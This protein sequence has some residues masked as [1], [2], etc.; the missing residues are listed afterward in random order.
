MHTSAELYFRRTLTP[1]ETREIREIVRKLRNANNEIA[2]ASNLESLSAYKHESTVLY[3]SEYLRPQYSPIV[4][5][6]AADG[7]GR[8]GSP[9]GIYYLTSAYMADDSPSNVKLASLSAIAAI[10]EIVLSAK[11]AALRTETAS[12]MQLI[13]PLSRSYF[14]SFASSGAAEMRE[15][16]EDWGPILTLLGG[17]RQA[18]AQMVALLRAPDVSTEFKCRICRLFISVPPND[19]DTLA[20]V[21]TQQYRVNSNLR[22]LTAILQAMGKIGRGKVLLISV[23][24]SS[25]TIYLRKTAIESLNLY[26]GVLL[27]TELLPLLRENNADLLDS[28]LTIVSHRIIS[29]SIDELIKNGIQSP[30]LLLAQRSCTALRKAIER[31][32]IEKQGDPWLNAMS[33]SSPVL[34]DVMET[35]GAN[36]SDL[37]RE[38]Y[39]AWLSLFPAGLE[40]MANYDWNASSEERRN[41]VALFR[42]DNIKRIEGMKKTIIDICGQPVASTPRPDPSSTVTERT[43]Q[44]RP[45]PP[46]VSAT[47]ATSEPRLPPTPPPSTTHTPPTVPSK[48][49]PATPV[50]TSDPSVPPPSRTRDPLPPP[51]PTKTP[52]RTGEPPRPTSKPTPDNPPSQ[53]SSPRPSPTPEPTHDHHHDHDD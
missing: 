40:P 21:L 52:P 8:T 49:L 2:I 20:S 3:L 38:A 25:N 36:A 6:A 41:Q 34:F 47:P 33:I 18:E 14:A 27:L 46:P 42:K 19:A 45:T 22:Y 31:W 43:S 24:R 35:D 4:R 12:K 53:T 11:D 51:P 17:D 16:V 39:M 29:S 7:L 15:G 44:P 5:I 9:I 32:K 10:A 30:D 13:L 23:A 50:P 1:P 37:R 48:T 28:V 26:N